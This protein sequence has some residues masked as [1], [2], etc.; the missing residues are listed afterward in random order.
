MVLCT[1]SV[2]INCIIRDLVRDSAWQSV[3]MT[4]RL[5]YG[6]ITSPMLQEV[7]IVRAHAS[8]ACGMQH[9]HH[10]SL[11]VASKVPPLLQEAGIIHVHTC[12]LCDTQRSKVLLMCNYTRTNALI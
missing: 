3:D 7:G 4:P 2:D 8:E 1:S 10:D 5:T 6:F 12:E 9:P 11:T